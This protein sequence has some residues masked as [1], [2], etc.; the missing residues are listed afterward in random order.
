MN[1]PNVTK[2]TID[3][4]NRTFTMPA[5]DIAINI[6]ATTEERFFQLFSNLK[7]KL[8]DYAIKR[9][10][11]GLKQ[12]TEVKLYEL[13]NHFEQYCPMAIDLLSLLGVFEDIQFEVSF[14]KDVM[15]P[16]FTANTELT[17]QF[18]LQ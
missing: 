18:C 7:S 13:L 8:M 3:P 2:T 15:C 16:S 5:V 6:T 10:N 17:K 14:I 1:H 9:L 4:R 12:K 11:D